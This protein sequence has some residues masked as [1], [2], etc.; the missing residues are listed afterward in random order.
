MS[1]SNRVRYFRF[2][3]QEMSQAELAE[4]VGVSRQTIV[5]IEKG[6]YNPSVELAL[7]LGK[8]LAASVEELFTLEKE[9]S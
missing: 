4:R 9:A 7:H 1:V 5:A 6:N 3:N 2:I 8:A